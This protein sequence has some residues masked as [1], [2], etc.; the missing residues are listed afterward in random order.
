MMTSC[1]LR[2]KVH[3]LWV[4]RSELFYPVAFLSSSQAFI[5]AS[6]DFKDCNPEIVQGMAWAVEMASYCPPVCDVIA[7]SVEADVEGVLCLPNILLLVLPAFDQVDHVPCLAGGCSTYVEGLF[8][9][10]TSKSGARLDMAADEAASGATG[11][12]STG[13]LESGWLKLCLD[14]QVPKVLWSSV[15]CKRPFRGGFFQAVGSM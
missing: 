5:K 7:M 14:Q 8:R 15:G 13:W 1:L 10:R 9:G 6:Y 12:T 11:A 4:Q 3:A 2:V